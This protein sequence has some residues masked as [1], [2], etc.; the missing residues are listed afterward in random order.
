[1]QRRKFGALK[2]RRPLRQLVSNSLKNRAKFINKRL[3]ARRRECTGISMLRHE[4]RTPLTGVLGMSELLQDSGL[5]GEQREFVLALRESGRQM[6]RLIRKSGHPVPESGPG[7]VTRPGPIDGLQLLEQVMRAHWP[8]ALKKGIGLHL[9]FDQR[10]TEQWH[11]DDSCLRQLLDNLLANAIKFTHGGHVLVEARP[12]S[13]NRRGKQ[14]IELRVSD[15][16]IGIADRDRHRIYRAGARG[17]AGGYQR[18]HGSGLGLYVCAR[19]TALLGGRVA[20]Q[21]N[22][23]GGTCFKLTLPAVA[24]ASPDTVRRFRPALLAGLRCELRLDDP[25][26]RV[27]THLLRR[28]GVRISHPGT[29]QAQV[30]SS[31]CDAVICASERLEDSISKGQPGAS[32]GKVVLLSRHI[33]A[34]RE[35]REDRH[36]TRVLELPQPILQSNLE[37]LLLQIALYRAACGKHRS[38]PD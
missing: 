24:E 15:T 30:F 33:P 28:I 12:A 37:P 9:V 18:Y 35:I 26:R 1:M 2:L 34:P 16:G 21:P 20:H 14:D 4:L 29:G 10:L 22:P 27:V 32:R 8:A 17:R 19:V 7:S 38:N 36:Q 3:S 5:S 11:S 25:A 13:L 23:G 6:E 31:R